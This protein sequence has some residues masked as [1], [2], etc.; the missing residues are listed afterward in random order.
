[1]EPTVAGVRLQQREELVFKR[2]ASPT[3]LSPPPP[4]FLHFL[5]APAE[6]LGVPFGLKAHRDCLMAAHPEQPS[7]L[8]GLGREQRAHLATALHHALL[9]PSGQA[10]GL[11]VPSTL[12]H[13]RNF[14]LQRLSGLVEIA[15]SIFNFF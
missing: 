6:F 13:R 9:P 4:P 12:P 2:V 7:K 15:V 11:Q 3:L 1:M 8:L 10:P 14:S 5:S